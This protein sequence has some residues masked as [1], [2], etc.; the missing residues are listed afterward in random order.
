MMKV[1]QWN[2]RSVVANG[3]EFKHY[4]REMN[5]KPEVICIQETFL[6]PILDFVIYGYVVIRRDRSE[7]EGTCGG[8]AIFIKQNIAYRVLEKGSDQEYIVVE[9][10]EGGEEVVI[11]NYYNPCKKLELDKLV[12]IKGTD[13]NKIVWCADFNAHNT[14]WGGAHT[15]TN[16]RVIEEL[17]EERGFV[18]MNDGR[19]TRI[20]VRTGKESAI[21]LTLVSGRLAGISKWEVLSGTTLGSDHYLVLCSVGGKVEVNAV[22]GIQKW[23]YSKAKWDKFKIV[24][25][26]IME[27]VD[28]SGDVDTL[29]STFTSAIIAGRLIKFHSARHTFTKNS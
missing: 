5:E 17:M 19:G 4:L 16:G 15:D 21:D 8:C 13:R 29:N 12:R 25:E 11:V 27:S 26:E 20:D 3:Q 7:G 6:M 24:S 23:V 28:M 1:L 14:M 10:W 22:N 18:C 2:A 9:V